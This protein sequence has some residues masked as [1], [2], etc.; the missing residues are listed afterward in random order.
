MSSRHHIKNDFSIFSDYQERFLFLPTFSQ[1]RV[2]SVDMYIYIL[3]VDYIQAFCILPNPC[4]NIEN[5][6][7][8]FIHIYATVNSSSVCTF[9][10]YYYR[11]I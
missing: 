1:L 7:F 3:V 8:H 4:A 6:F 5:Q 9:S 2:D 11:A 10:I